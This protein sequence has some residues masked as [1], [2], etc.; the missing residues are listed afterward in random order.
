M[1]LDK[2]RPL[3][4]RALEPFVEGADRIGLSPNGVSVLAFALAGVAAGTFYLAGATPGWYLIGALLVLLNGALDL[5]DGALARR[6]N[7]ASTAGDLL[8]HV[9]DRYADILIIA[10][11]AAGIGE[12]ALGFVAVTGV[13]MTSYLGTQA[14]AV[15]LDRVYGGL[16][17]RA[18]RLVLVGVVAVL[19]GLLPVTIGWFTLVGWLLVVFAV[20]GHVTAFQRFYHAMGTL[21]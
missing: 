11:L 20:V 15:G 10:G 4:D 3:A 1:T 12:Y 9:L 17:G 8:D 16:L 2:Y 6:Q 21:G 7:V 19:T 13:L 18:D 5:L 14:Q